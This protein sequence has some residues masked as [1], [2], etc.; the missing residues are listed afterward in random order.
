MRDRDGILPGHR[1]RWLGLA[2]LLAAVLLAGVSARNRTGTCYDASRLA[3]V[4]AVVDHHTFSIDASIFL[5]EASWDRM[6]IAGHFYSDKSPVPALLMAM[7]YQLLQ[8]SVGLLAREQMSTFIWCMTLGSSSVAYVAAVYCVYRMLGDLRLPWLDQLGL[9]VS[10]GLST[11]ALPYARHVNNHILLLAST[12]ALFCGLVRLTRAG[13]DRRSPWLLL[14]AG[15]LA[16][17]SYSIDL[18]AGPVLLAGALLLVAYRCRNA[19]GVW[20]FLLGAAPCVLVHHIANYLVGGTLKPA[21]AVPEYFRWP[22]SPVDAAGLTGAWHHP[23]VQAFLQYATGLLLGGRG[24]LWHNLP[25]LLAVPGTIIL[26]RRRVP[27][28]P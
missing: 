12:A 20:T 10:F 26:V 15:A 6:Y 11:L 17:L 23:S 14:G 18:G 2:I 19:R 27:E 4:E 25:I 16:G 24:F 22:G 1:P 28:M 5:K 13:A 7:L 9:T 8:W 21:N 3:T